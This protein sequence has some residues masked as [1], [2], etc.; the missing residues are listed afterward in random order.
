VQRAHAEA[1]RMTEAGRA[2]YEHAVAEG[3]AEQARLVAQT[4]VVQAAHIESGR[5]IDAGEREAGRLRTEC[6]QYIE[7]SLG[8]FEDTLTRT[9]QTV[10]RGRVH[11]GTR[12]RA[13]PIVPRDRIGTDLLD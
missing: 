13:E 1:E 12:G 7:S 11:R 6:D 9:L 2:S 5:I 10:Q 4:E 8:G 3:R